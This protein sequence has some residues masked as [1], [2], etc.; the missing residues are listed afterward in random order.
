MSGQPRGSS[1]LAQ[2]RPL[3]AEN[4]RVGSDMQ[5]KRPALSAIKFDPRLWRHPERWPHDPLNYAFLARA[6]QE[7]GLA[8]YGDEWTDRYIEPEEPTD[9]CDEAADDQYDRDCQQAELKFEKMH[10]SIASTIAEQ[11][12]LGNLVTALRHTAGGKMNPLDP[13]VWNTEY[14]GPRFFRCQ[15][16]LA[17]PFEDP[18]RVSVGSRYWIYVTRASLAR[19]IGGGSPALP[20]VNPLEMGQSKPKDHSGRRP[21]TGSWGIADK[22]LIEDMHRLISDGLAKSPNDAARQLADKAQGNS[23]P[24]SK[25]TRLAKAYRKKYPSGAK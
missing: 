3:S 8:R 14:F 1:G 4:R 15:M 18:A 10:A 5:S 2:C 22:P 9:D 12:E 11:S 13:Y 21:G 6:F 23:T 17:Q 7:I 19:Y 16:S 25:Q 24:A 20:L